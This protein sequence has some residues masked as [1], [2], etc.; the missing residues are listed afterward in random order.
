M[1]QPE[2]LSLPQQRYVE[3]IE[4]LCRTT[5]SAHTSDLAMRMNVRMPSVSEAV[6]RLVSQ[7]VAKR[8]SRH[9]IELT[10]KG[11][12]IAEQLKQRHKALLLFM[13]EVMAMEPARAD[14]MACRIEHCVDKEFADRLL[15]LAGFLERNHPDLLKAIARHVKRQAEEPG[16]EW[17]HFSI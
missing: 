5:G 16:Q 14:A 17:S 6:T 10:P 4:E 15:M 13:T 7:G 1:Q 9:T 3:T 12:A 2:A 8:N 11:R